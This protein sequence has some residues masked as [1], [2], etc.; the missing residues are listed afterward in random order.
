MQHQPQLFRELPSKVLPSFAHILHF[1]SSLPSLLCIDLA[2]TTTVPKSWCLL[3]K[4]M[5]GWRLVLIVSLNY[6]LSIFLNVPLLHNHSHISPRFLTS[7]K[8]ILISKNAMSLLLLHYMPIT[9][10]PWVGLL[11]AMVISSH[12]RHLS[13]PL[14][15]EGGDKEWD[16]C[17]FCCWIM[18]L[19]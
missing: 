4:Y 14:T 8:I 3:L 10:S 5:L 9:S 12:S 7:P 1:S 13:K 6:F 16:F 2:C 18:N 15:T 19:F 11:S 17:I